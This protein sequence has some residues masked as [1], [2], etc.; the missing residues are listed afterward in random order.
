MVSCGGFEGRRMC[1][2]VCRYLESK[3]RL[4]RRLGFTPGINVY[5]KSC[6]YHIKI[7]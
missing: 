6:R 1:L 2:Y 5:I 4:N 7:L 3:T